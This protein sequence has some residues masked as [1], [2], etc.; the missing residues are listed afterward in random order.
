MT[1]PNLQPPELNEVLD[2]LAANGIDEW[3]PERPTI[4]IDYGL[5]QITYTAFQFTGERGWDVAN[6]ASH[7]DDIHTE[8]RTVP[9]LVSPT[10]RIRALADRFDLK[11]VER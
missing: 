4:T 7:R 3:L 2:W 10:D 8:E 6:L 11:L 1:R 9:L 5:S